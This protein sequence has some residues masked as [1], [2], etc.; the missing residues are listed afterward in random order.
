[1]PDYCTSHPSLSLPSLLRRRG[2]KEPGP[3]DLVNKRVK[4]I[5]NLPHIVVYKKS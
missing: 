5:N 1:V 4:Y 3:T 2:G